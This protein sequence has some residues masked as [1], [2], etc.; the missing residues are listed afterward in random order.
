MVV[1]F[2]SVVI[3]FSCGCSGVMLVVLIFVLFELVF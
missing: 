2:F 3:L 1:V